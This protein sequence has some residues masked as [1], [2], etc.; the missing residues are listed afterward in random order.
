MKKQ[1]VKMM[2]IHRIYL[3]SRS[4]LIKILNKKKVKVQKM[5]IKMKMMK[6]MKLSIFKK[7]PRRTK[8]KQR[9]GGQVKLPMRRI[10]IIKIILRIMEQRARESILT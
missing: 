10:Q 8:R 3:K 2:K 6:K 1:I 5:T 4:K 9:K 7:V